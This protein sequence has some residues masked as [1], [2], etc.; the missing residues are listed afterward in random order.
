MMNGTDI[1]IIGFL[2]WAFS[3]SG[4]GEVAG[5]FLMLIGAIK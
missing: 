5:F 3:S 4:S 1:F 2:I